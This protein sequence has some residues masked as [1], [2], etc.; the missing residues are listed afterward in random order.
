[1]LPFGIQEES[2]RF[3]LN[4]DKISSEQ[5]NMH[6]TEFRCPLG[7]LQFNICELSYLSLFSGGTPIESYKLFSFMLSFVP[8]CYLFLSHTYTSRKSFLAKYAILLWFLGKELLE[9]FAF[10]FYDL[11]CLRV[12]SNLAAA[13]YDV[14]P[15]LSHDP[16]C[17]MQHLWW[18][19][20]KLQASGP[21]D[22]R[23]D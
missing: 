11:S 5:K 7:F 13:V 15:G 12:E 19:C 10:F 3:S 20:G 17:I 22:K 4:L 18:L 8:F 21:V 9:K 6:I 1:M 14:H 23:E 2:Q 16:G